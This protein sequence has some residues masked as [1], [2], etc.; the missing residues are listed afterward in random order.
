MVR[1]GSEQ[2]PVDSSVHAVKTFQAVNFDRV[3][4]S[5]GLRST[6]PAATQ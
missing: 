4:T 5:E 1:T 3:S 6:R 2:G